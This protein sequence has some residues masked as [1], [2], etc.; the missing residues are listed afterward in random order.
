MVVIPL[1]NAKNISGVDLIVSLIPLLTFTLV[2]RKLLTFCSRSLEPHLEY[3]STKIVAGITANTEVILSE[4][5]ARRA[6]IGVSFNEISKSSR[7]LPD[8]ST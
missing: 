1:L 4:T 3:I 2:V 5:D 7:S 6:F 8:S